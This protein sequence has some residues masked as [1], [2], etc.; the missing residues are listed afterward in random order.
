MGS[1][2]SCLL[3]VRLLKSGFEL[4]DSSVKIDRRSEDEPE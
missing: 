4:G 2:G 1:V 3:G